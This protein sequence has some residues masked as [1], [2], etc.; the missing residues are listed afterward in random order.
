MDALHYDTPA[1]LRI[2]AGS[3]EQ[4]EGGSLA[5]MVTRAVGLNGD[6]RCTLLLEVD[7]TVLGFGLIEAIYQRP[8]FPRVEAH[9]NGWI[10]Q[11]RRKA[12]AK[13]LSS[14][15]LDKVIAATGIDPSR[16]R[17]MPVVLLVEDEPLVRM[18][19]ADLLSEAGFEVVEAQDGDEALAALE[20]R[21][22][23]EVLFTDVNMPGSLDGLAL[24]TVARGRRPDLKVLV[25]S[26]VVRPSNGD[27]PNAG[28]FLAKPYR[29]AA[30]VETLREMLA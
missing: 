19:G 13:P 7:D 4:R 14:V 22:D 23:I 2:R 12:V 15:L 17:K 25:G 8:D 18:L 29:P 3:S 11:K 26:G 16:K 6:P 10:S 30:V 21:A 9:A 5:E 27:L 1:T 20:R 24:A 28:R